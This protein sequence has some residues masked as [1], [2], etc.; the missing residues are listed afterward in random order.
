LVAL[1]TTSLHRTTSGHHSGCRR[2]QS[3]GIGRLMVQGNPNGK[4]GTE[5]EGID[6]DI[7]I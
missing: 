4:Q 7:A 1:V 2:D 6:T 3:L 5:E